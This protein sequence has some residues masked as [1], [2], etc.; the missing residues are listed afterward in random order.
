M[1]KERKLLCFMLNP[2]NQELV[3]TATVSVF[4]FSQVH[5]ISEEEALNILNIAIKAN[6]EEKREENIASF[7]A[8]KKIFKDLES[9]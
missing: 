6:L 3:D 4:S 9:D 5:K 8:F 7:N 1:D 2:K